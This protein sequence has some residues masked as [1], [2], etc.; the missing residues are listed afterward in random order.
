MS[1][2]SPIADILEQI[3]DYTASVDPKL[4]DCLCERLSAKKIDDLTREFGFEL[5]TEVEDLYK[6]HNGMRE[7]D[8]ETH[9]LL[10]YH[11]FL[12]LEEALDLHQNF[13]ESDYIEEKGL[14][15][16]FEFEGEYYA[17]CCTSQK[18]ELAP[19]YFL[20]HDETIVYDSLTAM[21]S[22]ILECYQTGAYSPILDEDGEPLA[23]EV[24]ATQI[25]LKWNPVRGEM[26][27]SH[28]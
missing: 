26:R 23:N 18:Q 7:E 17:A 3:L 15:P 22:S 2:S 21:L 10:Y 5:P 14:L 4:R 1:T 19:I 25:K 9:R 11:Y 27:S 28:P 8:R 12:P 16:L 20:Y 24:L 6:W 13:L